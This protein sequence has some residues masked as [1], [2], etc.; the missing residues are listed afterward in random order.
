MYGEG[1]IRKKVQLLIKSVQNYSIV[2]TNNVYFCDITIIN[3][4]LT[5]N[6]K[7]V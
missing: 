2:E 5:T 4:K 6:C 1:K 7:T 3:Y